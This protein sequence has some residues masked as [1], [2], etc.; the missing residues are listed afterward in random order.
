LEMEDSKFIDR[1]NEDL[2]AFMGVLASEGERAAVVV[3][4][5]R[6]DLALERLLKSV[7]EPNPGGQDNLFAV[8][9]PLNSFGVKIALCYRLGLIDLELETILQS[10]KKMRNQFAHS[11][12]KESLQ[13]PRHRDC[14]AKLANACQKHPHWALFS[15]GFKNGVK[16]SSTGQAVM[17]VSGIQGNELLVDFATALT[18]LLVNFEVVVHIGQKLCPAYCLGVDSWDRRL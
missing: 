9:R 8:E 6:I 13:D 17:L 1:V 11:D 14:V 4:C 18:V 5:A 2:T 3:G 10:L 12:A 7:M 15:D 16:N